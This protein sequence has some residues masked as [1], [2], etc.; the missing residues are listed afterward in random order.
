M[1]EHKVKSPMIDL[2]L[3]H[4]YA[5][6]TGNV[7]AFLAYYALFTVLFLLPF[8]FEDVLNY[9]TAL[10]GMLLMPVPAS[11][12]VL[13]PFAGRACDRFGARTLT[14][15]GSMMLT[16]GSAMLMLTSSNRDPLLLVIAM[17]ILGAGLGLFTP[18]NNRATMGAA[19]RDKLGVMGGLLNMMR[20]LGLIFGID[21]SGMLFMSVAEMVS[22][23]TATDH[24]TSSAI[25]FLPAPAFMDGFH[26]VMLTLV[27]IVLA[28]T[29]L[30]F[31]RGNEGRR[32]RRVHVH[33]PIELM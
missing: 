7:T 31:L 28:S 21:I 32:T 6:V 17:V 12:A 13:A 9:S 15:V 26:L 11:M 8:Y 4:R 30:S 25:A 22:P 5:L 14:I 27:G 3:F 29:V 20:S 2:S 33:E 19:P 1:V 23:G 16:V 18:A 10:S 24:G